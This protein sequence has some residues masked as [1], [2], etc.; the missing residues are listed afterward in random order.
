MKKHLPSFALTLSLWALCGVNGCAQ[1]VS[2]TGNGV[3]PVTVPALTVNATSVAFGN[4]TVGQAATQTLQLTSS[5]TASVTVSALTVSGPE[6]TASNITL[7]LTLAPTNTASVSVT[8]APTTAGA[9]AGSVTIVS[10]ATVSPVSTVTLAATAVTPNYNV[11]LS[12]QPPASSVD[13]V[14]NYTVYR[15][16]H[17]TSIYA[18]IGTVSVA[19][20]VYTDATVAQNTSYDYMV[21]SVDAN[22]VQSSPSNTVTASIP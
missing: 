22:G 20:T 1:T 21:V 19:V 8:F 11:N 17:G 12:W 4:V 13:P 14:A 7:P 10:N 18:A 15:A 16:A 5:G 2:L 6:F 9:A 3:A